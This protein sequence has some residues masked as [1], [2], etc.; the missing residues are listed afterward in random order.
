MTR[1]HSPLPQCYSW[2]EDDPN[3]RRW[4]T[5][6]A[7]RLLRI[8]GD[9]GKGKTMLMISLVQKLQA[10]EE[11]PPMTYFFCQST[12]SRLHSAISVLQGLIWHLVTSNPGLGDEFDNTFQTR[13]ERP[14]CSPNADFA[15]LSK[16]MSKL[17]SHP[18]A[19]R[20]NVLIDALDECDVDKDKLLRFIAEDSKQGKSK[21]KWLVSS[22]NHR[23]VEEAL[24][25]PDDNLTTLSLELNSSHVAQAVNSFIKVQAE[26]LARKKGLTADVKEELQQELM[27]KAD[28]TFLWVALVT[29]E[30]M[31]VT[32]RKILNR[33]R[34]YPPTL[35]KFYERM[36]KHL[37]DQDDEEDRTLCT[38]VMRGVVLAQRPLSLAE[39]GVV[40]G[41]P[42][43]E[44]ARDEDISD[45]IRSCGSF[46]DIRDNTCYFVH[47]SAKDFFLDAEA[48]RGI[49]EDS[50][51][52]EHQYIVCRSLEAMSSALTRDDICSLVYPG[53][54]PPN[55]KTI[56]TSPLWPIRYAC[57]FWMAHLELSFE[58]AV[59]TNNTQTGCLSPNMAGRI[60]DF[61][62][63]KYLRWVEALA[64]LGQL[65]VAIA[66]LHDLE[67]RCA[68]M[69]DT[70]LYKSFRDMKRILMQCGVGVSE[71]PLQ[72]Y[73]SALAFAPLLSTTRQ[74]FEGR[75]AAWLARPLPR[76]ALQWDA[77]LHTLEG[78]SSE[79]ITVTFSPDGRRLASCSW[80][81][82]VRLW[83]A[84]TGAALHTLKGH[85]SRVIAVTF[86]CDGRRLASCSYDNTVR[87]WDADTGAALH[88]LEGHSWKV[89]AVTFSPDGR[90]LASCSGDRTVRLWDADTGAALHTL[91]GHSHVVNAVTFSPDGRRLAS[92]SWDNTVRLWDADTG[93][94]LHTLEGHR[95]GVTAVTFSPDGRRLASCSWDSTVGLWDPSTGAALHTLKGHSSGVTAVT[96]SPDGRRLASCSHDKT[97]RL[98]DADTG[99]ALHT[100]EGHSKVVDAVTFSPDGRRLASPA[101]AGGAQLAG[102][103]GDVLV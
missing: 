27:R 29:K 23:N 80:D 4:E 74:R 15:E 45:L 70:N 37:L 101:H 73:S 102:H 39:L 40:A 83:D 81:S 72:I 21:A 57:T 16:L 9:P 71:A 95:S 14:F 100:L 7:C 85:S 103:G 19:T 47:Q 24:D 62:A 22:R 32:A 10:M 82:T 98:W 41:L 2:I 93:A 54:P 56:S 18:K 66:T 35:T 38:S 68:G 76:V 51:M 52:A 59:G 91:E 90:R 88:T 75:S 34:V 50:L 58:G 6:Q 60:Y 17:L 77:T 20:I 33:A 13:G 64:N 31:N 53:S 99:A 55:L 36:L 43:T 89:N 84:G 44:F 87:L 30:L 86:S 97:V 46:V 94:A 78:H 11:G 49:F 69:G 67:Q 28:A 92:C 1:K 42:A 12:D 25:S 79:V 26:D 8:G 63:E 5:D 96:F 3:L 65:S 61:L 48:G